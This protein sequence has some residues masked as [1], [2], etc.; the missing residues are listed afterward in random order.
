MGV[1]TSAWT[2]ELAWAYEPAWAKGHQHGSQ[3]NDTGIR[4]KEGMVGGEEQL[5]T[6]IRELII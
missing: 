5:I 6:S 3:S 1:S 4:S 2:Y